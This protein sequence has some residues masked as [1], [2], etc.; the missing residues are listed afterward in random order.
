MHGC[1]LEDS[2]VL[3]VHKENLG[4]N[5][6]VLAIE[7]YGESAEGDPT[8]ESRPSTTTLTNKEEESSSRAIGSDRMGV[9]PS[10]ETVVYRGE[11]SWRDLT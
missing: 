1:V 11:R 9:A 7:G 8:A 6:S 4:V 3:V 10:T 5:V 2:A